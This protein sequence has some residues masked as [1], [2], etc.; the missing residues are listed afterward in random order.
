MNESGTQELS[1]GQKA[2]GINF[3][4]TGD[5]NVS[6][7]KEA[8]AKVID[9]LNDQRNLATSGEVKRML[10]VAITEIQSGQMWGVKAV[11]WK[12]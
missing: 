1:F 10:S 8:C 2:V 5:V 9:V 11:T 12:E 3:N 7:I 4:V 6:A